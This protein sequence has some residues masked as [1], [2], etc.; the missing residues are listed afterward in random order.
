MSSERISKETA[1]L[2]PLPPYSWYWKPASFILDKDVV[3]KHINDAVPV[4]EELMQNIKSES[5]KN[6]FL[7]L[8]S[9][10]PFVGGQRMRAIHE[11]RKTD[12]DFDPVIAIAHFDKPYENIWFLWKDEEFRSKAN[13]VQYQLWELVFKSQWYNFD[14]TETGVDMRY[15]ETL[16]DQLSGWKE[17]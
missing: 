3:K 6:P 17:A 12:K 11:I 8:N 16:G 1:E 5:I 9:W 4:N 2:C 13:A 7:C 14:K 10:W 15:Y